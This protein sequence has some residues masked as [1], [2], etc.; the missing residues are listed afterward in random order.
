MR[1]EKH[2]LDGT[3]R[4]RTRVYEMPPAAEAIP[5]YPETREYWTAV[6][7]VPCPVCAGGMIRWN[8]AGYV[9]G[10]RICD[11]CLRHFVASGTAEEPTLLRMRR[12][13]G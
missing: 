2:N 5:G 11:K 1:Y 9:P 10:Y 7:D 3:G 4:R 12:R 13:R 6:T 8:E